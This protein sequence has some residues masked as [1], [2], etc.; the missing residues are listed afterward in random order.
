MSTR[1]KRPA[2][3]RPL[4]LTVLLLA[5]LGYLGYNCVSGQFGIASQR[6]MQIEIGQL[7]AQSAALS[8]QIESLKNRATLFASDRLDPDILTERARALLAMAHPG[9]VL[10]MTDPKTG[11][12]ISGSSMPSTERKLNTNIAVGID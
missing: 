7:E 3:W 8:V 12:P 11:L 10:V 6:A 5:V 4:G 2:R 1:L 9:D